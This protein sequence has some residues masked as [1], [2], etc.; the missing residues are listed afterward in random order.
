MW[1]WWTE[2]SS[3][4]QGFYVAAAALSLLFLWQF[5][6]SLIGLA[7]GEGGVDAVDVDTDIDVGAGLDLDDIE[8][9]SLEEA[10][11]SMAGFR[12]IS[13]RAI[14]AFATLFCWAAALYLDRGPSC[15]DRCSTP[16][17]GARAAGRWSL[18]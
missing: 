8:V 12:M 10:A 14:L 7:G 5:I 4:V 16:S 1:Q 17:P 11:E 6:A 13:L 3:L 15:L 2:L 9:H 18:S